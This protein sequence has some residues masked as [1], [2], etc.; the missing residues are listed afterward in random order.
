MYLSFQFPE[1]AH[2]GCYFHFLQSLYRRIQTL[3]LATA[4]SKDDGIRSCL[5]KL[6]ALPYL[7]VHEVENSFHTL[8]TTL[9]A[10]V[11]QQVRQ[12]F[13]YFDDYWMNTL[14]LKMWNVHN[15]QH[16]TNNVCE[17]MYVLS[18]STL[19]YSVYLQVFIID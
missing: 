19:S 5:R 14:P 10:I 6:M 9:D 7:P 13:L 12:L 18:F 1:S 15:C 2:K 17:G 11:K 16:R 4:Y 8:R 3:G